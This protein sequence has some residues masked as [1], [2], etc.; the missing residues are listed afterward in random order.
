MNKKL[1]WFLFIAPIVVSL[2]TIKNV[3]GTKEVLLYIVFFILVLGPAFGWLR[4]W[5]NHW[6][7]FKAN[8]PPTPKRIP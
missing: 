1:F 3:A 8:M 7:K 5:N 4:V 6:A 2:V